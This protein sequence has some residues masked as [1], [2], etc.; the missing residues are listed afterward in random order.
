MDLLKEIISLLERPTGLTIVGLL[1][2]LLAFIHWT[3]IHEFSEVN[4]ENTSRI[5]E[6]VTELR[7]DIQ[8]LLDRKIASN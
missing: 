8:K 3:T 2:G 6:A 1:L 7:A 5:V 4:R